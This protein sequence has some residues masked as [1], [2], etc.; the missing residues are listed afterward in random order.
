MKPVQ[1]FRAN[2]GKLFPS[3]RDCAHYEMDQTFLSSLDELSQS[4]FPTGAA[5]PS[6]LRNPQAAREELMKWVVRKQD[7]LCS[8]LM[9]YAKNISEFNE[10][11][12]KEDKDA[13]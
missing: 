7:A 3:E 6:N 2:D 11:Y 12:P 10:L 5:S 1:M 9:E 4:A 8:L 13:S